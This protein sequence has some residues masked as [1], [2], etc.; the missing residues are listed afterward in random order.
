MH[1]SLAEFCWFVA[2]GGIGFVL[3]ASLMILL[4]NWFEQSLLV[5]RLTS[6]TI[7]AT[8]C[9]Y[10]NRRLTFYARRSNHKGREWSKYL[11]INGLGGVI[12]MSVF[13]VLVYSTQF[14]QDK[15]VLALAGATGVSLSVNFF[16]S[17]YLVF[18]LSNS[19]ES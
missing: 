3:D 13:F 10:L 17:K 19:D 18:Q 9:W 11:L 7:G 6:F 16:G 4:Y 2:V 5:S 15:F 8:L 12:N 1:R 14:F